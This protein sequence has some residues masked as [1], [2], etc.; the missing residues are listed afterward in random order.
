MATVTYRGQVEELQGTS[1]DVPTSVLQAGQAKVWVESQHRQQLAEAAAQ[2]EA[3]QRQQELLAARLEQSRL[4]AGAQAADPLP[5]REELSAEFRGQ[6]DELSHSVVAA[7]AAIAGRGEA[8]AAARADWETRH[9]TLVSEAEAAITEAQAQ[10]Q[11]AQAV[12]QASTEQVQSELTSHRDEVRLLENELR[13]TVAGLVGPQGELGP[14]G[15]AGASTVIASEDPLEVDPKSFATRWLGR[16]LVDGDGCLV[17]RPNEVLVRRYVRGQWQA[18]PAIEPKVEVRDVKA[19][20]L[21]VNKPAIVGAAAAGAAGSTGGGGESLL[22]NSINGA[23]GTQIKIADAS[24]WAIPLAARGWKSPQSCQLVIELTAV[25]GPA[26]GR[27]LYLAAGVLYEPGNVG[28]TDNTKYS[29]F[30]MLGSLDPKVSVKVEITMATASIPPGITVAPPS[31]GVVAPSIYL[32]IEGNV[33]GSTQFLL[34][35]AIEWAIPHE[36]VAQPI[37]S[38][39]IIQPAWQL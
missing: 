19:S 16:P 24:R 23:A 27:K 12:T 3:D 5:T 13:E 22:V 36:S 14:Q 4:A 2:A 17:L 39:A 33:S 15:I 32:T 9:E 10:V 21:Q 8:E 29:E 34:A 11:A 26:A 6:L 38:P 1:W 7:A 30:S 28:G 25:N 31:A 20:V 37:G 35:G 18:G